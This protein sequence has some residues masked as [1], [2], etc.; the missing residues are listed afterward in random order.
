MATAEISQFRQSNA[1]AVRQ[2]VQKR[3]I[4]EMPATIDKLRIQPQR[5]LRKTESGNSDSLCPSEFSVVELL[6]SPIDSPAPTRASSVKCGSSHCRTSSTSFTKPQRA[7][8]DTESRTAI[9]CA[10]LCSPWLNCV[11]SQASPTRASSVE[12]GYY[13]RDAS[14]L[15][16]GPTPC[17]VLVY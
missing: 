3:C 8:R 4:A 11:S 15:R 7:Q 14:C 12:C 6:F 16:K 9:L 2:F 17:F 5:T 1:I 13:L 10:P